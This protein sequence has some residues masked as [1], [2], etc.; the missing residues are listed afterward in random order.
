MV[1]IERMI[2]RIGFLANLNRRQKSGTVPRFRVQRFRVEKFQASRLRVQGYDKIRDV[3]IVDDPFRLE[4]FPEVS[5][6]FF[7]REM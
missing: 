6:R 5:G 4:R 3:I 7:V 1:A 2:Y